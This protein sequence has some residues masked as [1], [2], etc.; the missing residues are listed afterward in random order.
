VTG[1]LD[2]LQLVDDNGP[3]VVMTTIKGVTETVI[4]DEAKVRERY[5]L[6]PKQIPD[7]KAFKGDSS[8]N[9]PGVPG[10]GDKTAAKI[11][12]KYG[13]VEAVVEGV[14]S[15]DDPKLQTLIRQYGA[16]AIRFKDLATI[17][18]NVPLDGFQFALDYQTRG[19][20]VNEA[21][22]L[23]ERLEFRTLVKRL[24]KPTPV[25]SV[26]PPPQKSNEL[27]LDFD[28]A[29][30]VKPV[31]ALSP[32][33][34]VTLDFDVPLEKADF[35]SSKL[36]CIRLSLGDGAVS[37]G[38]AT[39]ITVDASALPSDSAVK[40]ILE[41]ATIPKIIHDKKLSEGTLG[42]QGIVLRGVVFDTLLAAYLI[43]A[44]RSGYKLP[45]LLADFAGISVP[46]GT[47][48]APVH[49]RVLQ[50]ILATR[51]AS[52]GLTD[53]HDR[54]ELPLS[55]ILAGMESAGVAV[56]I[57]WLRTVSELMSRQIGDLESKICGHAGEKF[58]IG[59]TKQ[60]QTILFEKLALP[61]G[62]K[63]KTG[64]S[65]DSE[66][67]DAL[68]AAG[69][70]IA[71]LI[72][73]WRELSKLKSTYAD[74][75]QA[76]VSPKDGRVH[77]TLNQTVAATGRLSSTNPNLQNIPVRT[78]VGREIRKSFIA[79]PGKVLL[80]V[81]YSQIELRIF[82]HMTQDTELI[83]TFR[84]DEDIH[85]RTAFFSSMSMKQPSRQSSAV[86]RRQSTLRLSTA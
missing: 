2:A 81:D 36:V 14:D 55:S 33:S 40:A 22:Q 62:K 31:L 18:T 86:A 10:I 56:D 59:S 79:D 19:I 54:I 24:G 49:L 82:A 85:R 67:L 51:L 75:L 39:E 27:S 52:A 11:L 63:T 66:V 28:S 7:Y 65:T 13:T 58:S 80:A 32:I 53:L 9:L 71:G 61:A 41:D 37:P 25:A 5:G 23:F 35:L 34:A 70:E 42:E 44:G 20:D 76:L 77:T 78:E 50:P 6:N 73:Q 72:T 21:T 15:I 83:R 12:N 26:T 8:D 29:D 48:P 46:S 69:Y 74:N 43:N 64:F 16:D 38:G 3:V 68:A 45:D 57:K 60:L 4:Y 84:A 30:E 17:R 47:E 1:D